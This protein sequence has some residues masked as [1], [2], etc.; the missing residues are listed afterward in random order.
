M[1]NSFAATGKTCNSGS[2]KLQDFITVKQIQKCVNLALTSGK[3]NDQA[4]RTNVNDLAAG[5]LSA[6]ENNTLPLFCRGT[7]P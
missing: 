6:M 7:G 5:K 2:G 3:L 4:V 1:R